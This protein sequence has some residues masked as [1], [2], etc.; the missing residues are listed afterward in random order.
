[1]A[2]CTSMPFRS[3]C[4]S[5][6]VRAR[7]I[8]RLQRTTS[9]MS[10]ALATPFSSSEMASRASACWMRLAMK[11]GMSRRTSTGRL[12]AW[13]STSITKPLLAS[14][15]LSPRTTS[16]SGITSAGLKKCAPTK[17]LRRSG[18]TATA[19]ALTDRPEVLVASTVRC[20]QRASSSAKMRRFSSSFSGT[21]SITSSAWAA[22]A[23]AVAGTSRARAAR[24]CSGVASAASCRSMA[25]SARA[26]APSTGSTST[27]GKPRSANNAASP[28]PMEPAPMMARRGGSDEA[29]E[30]VMDTGLSSDGP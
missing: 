16:T 1:M 18:D 15:V 20:G 21:A 9:S 6:P 7:R 23:C 5:G 27:T 11:P 19:I 2:W 26:R 12:P 29:A 14:S 22:A 10:A 17:R 28:L 25:A 8:P 4:S 3:R 24:A 30:V 13:R